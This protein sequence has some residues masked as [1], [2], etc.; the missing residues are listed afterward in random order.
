MRIAPDSP[1][2]GGSFESSLTSQGVY[3]AGVPFTS[4]NISSRKTRWVD[5]S[6]VGSGIGRS[7]RHGNRPGIECGA[8]GGQRPRGTR[9]LVCQRAGNHV[10][11]SPCEH[12]ADPVRKPTGLPLEPLHVSPCTLNQQAP[13]IFFPRLLMPSRFA[14]PP[15]LYWR[16]TSPIDAAKS[17]LLPYCLPSPISAAST[18]AVIGPTPGIVSRRWPRS[19]SASW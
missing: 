1:N 14:R 7:D 16:G 6:E 2:N 8:A 13:E 18:L 17:R 10:G 9:Q 4:S 11:V 5:F 15:V 12:G 3:Q 19:S